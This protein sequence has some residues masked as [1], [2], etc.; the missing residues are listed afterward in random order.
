MCMQVN[1]SVTNVL[2]AF[3]IL[4]KIGCGFLIMQYSFCR[5]VVSGV[6]MSY[7]INDY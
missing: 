3:Y 1:I 5:L 2:R 6:I 4:Y 7:K